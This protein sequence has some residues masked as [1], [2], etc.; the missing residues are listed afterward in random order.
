VG[1]L[2]TDRRAD[3]TSKR[4]MLQG[5]RSRVAKQLLEKHIAT[6]TLYRD[7]VL[8]GRDFASVYEFGA[9]EE[10]DIP[11]PPSAGAIPREL[12]SKTSPFQIP[13]PVV[14]ELRN[15][16]L[17]GRSA[18]GFVREG[19]Y[20]LDTAVG[21]M[22]VLNRS[23][24]LREIAAMAPPMVWLPDA[25]AAEYECAVSL[26]NVWS[27]NYFHWIL[28]GLTRLEGLSHYEAETGNKPQL[29]IDQNPPR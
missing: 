5:V 1:V 14:A 15:A 9:A 17:I 6:R 28:E 13:K 22:Y 23:L 25:K 18:V 8:A 19:G 26:V 2:L 7:A 12:A 3:W 27:R 21:D 24:S 16:E 29:I 20:V 11:T 4:L 10:V